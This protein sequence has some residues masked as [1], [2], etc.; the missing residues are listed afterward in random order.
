MD[1]NRGETLSTEA[2]ITNVCVMGMIL[3][4]S[5]AEPVEDFTVDFMRVNQEGNICSLAV[6]FKIVDDDTGMCGF[7]SLHMSITQ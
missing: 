1:Q 2:G 4:D 5:I 6:S 3:E 7:V